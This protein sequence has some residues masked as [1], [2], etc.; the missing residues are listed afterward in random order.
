M[1]IGNGT[2]F[3]NEVLGEVFVCVLADNLLS[4]PI[5]HAWNR[6]TLQK[7]CSSWAHIVWGLPEVWRMLY[8]DEESTDA[9]IR[10]CLHYAGALS[11]DI[12]LDLSAFD[13]RLGWLEEF[14]ERKF[15][16]LDDA[17]GGSPSSQ[18]AVSKTSSSTGTPGQDFSD[19]STSLP[20]FPASSPTGL[21]VKHSFVQFGIF[22]GGDS[23]TR[24]EIGPIA[25]EAEVSARQ[26]MDALVPC[27]KLTHLRLSDIHTSD[28][29]SR[30]ILDPKRT[31]KMLHLTHL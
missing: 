16:V 7:V 28:V 1:N 26:I 4:D 13:R 21:T 5:T 14:L 22:V 27:K 25:A 2:R 20:I 17:L 29:P 10:T 15:D 23:L 31:P 12:F 6:R 8:I 11:L 9:D 24:L 19:A 30:S 18:P 3:P